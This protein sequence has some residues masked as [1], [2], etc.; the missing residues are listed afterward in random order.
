VIRQA[1]ADCVACD[2]PATIR[3]EARAF[4]EWPALDAWASVSG[5]DLE[6]VRALGCA[7]TLRGGFG[8]LT[9]DSGRN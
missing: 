7:P 5:V 8:E 3:A 6:I 9:N 2:A 4:I 1:V